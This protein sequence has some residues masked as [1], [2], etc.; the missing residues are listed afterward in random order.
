MNFSPF[1]AGDDSSEHTDASHAGISGA[2]LSGL[3]A[4]EARLAEDLSRL[5]L[6]AKQW[7]LQ[8]HVDGQDVLDVAVI[9]GGMA[10]LAASTAIRNMGMRV[11]IFDRSPEGFEGPWAT[12]ARMETLRSPKQ[13]TGPALG[14]A[15]LTFRAWFEAQFGSDA[16]QTLDKIARLQWMAYLRWYR[17]VMKVDIRNDQQVEKI[18]PRDDGLIALTIR[19]LHRTPNKQTAMA[20]WGV[21]DAAG[22]ATNAA[23]NDAANNIHTAAENASYVVLT[24][25]VVLATGRDGLGGPSVPSFVETLPRKLWAHSSD[26]FDYSRLTGKRVAVIG[27]GAST[28]DSAATALESGARSVDVL[29]RR[30]DFPR[31][32]KSKGAG[33][34]GLTHG[35]Q[36]LPD[37]WRWRIRHYINTV[38]VPPPR[39]STLR[40]GRHDNAYFNFG[41]P[42]ISVRAQA[43]QNGDVVL[44]DTPKGMFTAD[45]L[46]VA[47]GF[48]V[49]WSARSE[50]AAFA[51]HIRLWQDR[52][53]PAAGDEDEE[54]AGSPDLGA[55]FEFKE[56]EP[57]SCPALARI[58]CFC[59][60][61]ML[62]HGPVSGDI[63]AI[64]AGALRLAQGIASSLYGEDVAEHY[65]NIKRYDDPELLGDEWRPADASPNMTPNLAVGVPS[66]MPVVLDAAPSAAPNPATAEIDADVANKERQ[67]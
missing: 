51:P 43:A 46:I 42:I 15:S 53:T 39:G 14:L 4:L 58:H 45:F 25:R 34:P 52:F 59:S 9:G 35:H 29:I 61:A 32:N 62:T 55:A 21:D 11:R 18:V 7:V 26:P 41:C 67:S 47:T 24:R 19:E 6:P 8:K 2:G 63:P 66:V 27:A 37:A 38:R 28:M 1:D 30:D 5:E 31:V 22:N 50:F 12:T 36:H 57:G 49:D 65:E 23:A 40:V 13:L 54:L 64:S 48:K 56:R 20:T 60:P 33:N 16:W 44:I 17:R 3:D 10:G